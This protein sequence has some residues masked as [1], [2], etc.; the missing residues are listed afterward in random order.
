MCADTV[1]RIYGPGLK[2]K[3]SRCPGAQGARDIDTED[4]G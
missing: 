1:K 2:R 4:R 3:E